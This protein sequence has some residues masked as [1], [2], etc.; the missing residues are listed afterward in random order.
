MGDFGRKS[1]LL[2]AAVTFLII[3]PRH[4][5]AEETCA[6]KEKTDKAETAANTLYDQDFG[7]ALTPEDLLTTMLSPFSSP[8]ML[9]DYFRPWRL[10]AVNDLGSTIKTDKDKF[11]VNLDVQHFTPDEIT[12]KTDDGF[13]IVEGK[14]EEKKD[15]H[16]MVARQFVRKYSLPRGTRPE[17]VSSSISADGVLT[18]TAPLDPSAAVGLRVVPIEKTGPV[19]KV[20]KAEGDGVEGSCNGQTG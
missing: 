7:M 19:R 20:K 15:D 13:I 1:F 3:S 12:V 2:A 17:T 6:G 10:S 4:I 14:H 5:M 9:R 18:V 16:G 11:Q 8:W